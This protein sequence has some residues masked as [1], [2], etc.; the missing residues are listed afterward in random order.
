M[1]QQSLSSM[2]VSELEVSHTRD[3]LSNE[4][5]IEVKNRNNCYIIHLQV[6]ILYS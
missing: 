6:S 5:K 2:H 3:S 1:T 4:G